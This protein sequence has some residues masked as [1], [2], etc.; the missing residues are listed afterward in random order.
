MKKVVRI[1]ESDLVR[2]VRQVIKE[3]DEHQSF[4]DK[5]KQNL[6]FFNKFKLTDERKFKLFEFGV[7]QFEK[8]NYSDNANLTPENRVG[9]WIYI[10]SDVIV[11]GIKINFN[12]YV[13]D[14]KVVIKNNKISSD[15]VYLNIYNP[16]STKG[17]KDFGFIDPSSSLFKRF[18]KLVIDTFSKNEKY[19]SLLNKNINI[20]TPFPYEPK[21]NIIY[22][23][24]DHHHHRR[25]HDNDRGFGGFGGG[26]FGGAG[27]GGNW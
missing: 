15:D 23:Y 25:D 21:D 5:I 16:Q 26:S 12:L 20:N 2:L 22:V 11:D 14:M 17:S 8:G 7:K 4:S 18:E 10:N 3:N 6:L 19:M 13:R 9:Y 24:D 27:A 1:K